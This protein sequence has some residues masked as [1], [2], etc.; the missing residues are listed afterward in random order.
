MCDIKIIDKARRLFFVVIEAQTTRILT[1]SA[2]IIRSNVNIP[3]VFIFSISNLNI[4]VTSYPFSLRTCIHT[5]IWTILDFYVFLAS[6]SM[7]MILII[8]KPIFVIFMLIIPINWLRF[9]TVFNERLA[10]IRVIFIIWAIR[11]ACVA[12][13]SF[14]IVRFFS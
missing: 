5:T 13:K 7:L 4:R 6:S 8:I 2:G 14:V 9:L 11:G 12:I 1:I 10:W 3:D